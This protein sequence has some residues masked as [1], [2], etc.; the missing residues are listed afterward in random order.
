[1]NQQQQV[2]ILSAYLSDLPLRENHIRTLN[3]SNCIEE[4]GIKFRVAE[5]HYKGSSEISF[6]TLPKNDDEIQAL[7]DFAFK[8]FKQES[9][10]FQ[11]TNGV[12]ELIYSDG[13]TD[14][15]NRLRQVNPKL[16]EKLDSYTVM[17][18]KVYTTEAV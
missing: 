13:K 5:G 16:I 2:L 17:G 9:V 6:V 7:K 11:D 8:N 10:L 15:L 4:L 1:M 14:R 12:T 18:G 3:L